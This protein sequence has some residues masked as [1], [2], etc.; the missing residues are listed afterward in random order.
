MKYLDGNQIHSSREQDHPK[1]VLLARAQ[2]ARHGKSSKDM[3]LARVEELPA[4][5]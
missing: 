4:S 5:C 3:A 2:L 1:K